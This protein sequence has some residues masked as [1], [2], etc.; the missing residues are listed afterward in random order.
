M[1]LHGL[2]HAQLYMYMCVYKQLYMYMCIYIQ[3]YMYTIVYVYKQC[4]ASAHPTC[5]T[6]NACCY[7]AQAA[8]GASKHGADATRCTHT[9]E[10]SSEG[11]V[12]QWGAMTGCALA[13]CTHTHTHNMPTSPLHTR[14]TWCEVVHIP[15]VSAFL[16]CP[17]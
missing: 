9:T 1:W 7:G 13:P 3:L 6:C 14:E 4:A 17:Q 2:Q 15:P 11:Q 8:D 5:A 16:F 12:N 10:W